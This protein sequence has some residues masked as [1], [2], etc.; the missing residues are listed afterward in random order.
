MDGMDASS[1][2]RSDGYGRP[3]LRQRRCGAGR[4][5]AEL[6][7]ARVEAAGHGRPLLRPG[8]SQKSTIGGQSHRFTVYRSYNHSHILA[9]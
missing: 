2:S 7:T 9:F 1:T 4:R 8:R 5:R 3:L 6:A